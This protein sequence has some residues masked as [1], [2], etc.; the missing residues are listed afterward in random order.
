M[1]SRADLDRL[2][3]AE[4][5]R[6]RSFERSYVRREQA[7]STDLVIRL[8]ETALA[9]YDRTP[10][11]RADAERRELAELRRWDPYSLEI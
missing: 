5:R 2:L 1:T 6:R 11:G 9:V 7:V 8:A 3:A 4:Q 10:Q